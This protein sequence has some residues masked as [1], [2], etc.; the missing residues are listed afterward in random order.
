MNTLEIFLLA[1]ALSIDACVVAFSQGLIVK[2]N[3]ILNSIKLSLSVSIGQAVM[4]VIGWYITMEV[5][6]YIEGIKA[7]DHWIAFSIFALLGIKFIFDGLKKG[8]ENI[9]N[10]SYISYSKLLLFGTATSID[11]LVAGSSLFLVKT[12][13][14]IPAIIIGITTLI[15]SMVAFNASKI[16]KNHKSNVLEILA[17]IIL[18]LLGAKIL[19]QHM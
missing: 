6:R 19:Y 2:T 15:S 18:I 4:P 7:V 16:F 5:S 8:E 10:I 11:A 14:L 1:I 12:K 9:C 13:I 17:G 3:R